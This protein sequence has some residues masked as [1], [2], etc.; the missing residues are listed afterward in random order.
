M[1]ILFYA[2]HPTQSNGYA[3]V[4]NNI[5][6]YLASKENVEVYYFGITAYTENILGRYIH[7]NIR[8]INVFEQSPSKNAYGD[9]LIVPA[10]QKIQPDIVFLYNDILV[11]TRMLEQI[12]TIPKTF[13]IYTY[14]DLVYEYEHTQLI[15]YIDEWT[16]K[17]FVFSECWKKNLCLIGVREDKMF[18][19][20]HGLD[21]DKIQKIDKDLSRKEI[22][23]AL[24]DFIVLNLNR[25]THRKGIDVTISAF[26]RFLKKHSC[27]SRIKLYLTGNK[28]PS[29]YDNLEILKV[30]CIQLN[31]DYYKVIHEHVL[32]STQAIMTDQ[33]VNYLY[34]ACDVGINTCFG[35]GFGL[36]SLEH[37]AVGKPQVIA[38][39]GA[40]R[41]IFQEGHCQLVEPVGK[42]YIPT[43]LDKTG[44]YLE[45]CRVED[46][47]DALDDY[48]L[49]KEKRY[50]D[51]KFYEEK[52]P[53]E[54]KWDDILNEFYENHIKKLN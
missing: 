12:R 26:L 21:T 25:N 33:I 34:N 37:A 10:I 22:G 42:I 6:N 24:D 17:F 45:I 38:G 8:L 30:E 20:K 4:G 51:G 19:L 23:L 35:E 43:I 49:N 46:F 32:I 14:I 29:S 27:D 54:Y 3:R 11:I 48:Y 53:K 2:T 28:E 15:Q 40:L 36:C 7:P 41:D 5:S 39:V 9:D 31:L 13:Q 52:I 18:L 47:A 16:D 50:E 1:K 44:G